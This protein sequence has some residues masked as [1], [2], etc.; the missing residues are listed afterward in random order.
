MSININKNLIIFKIL[1][2]VYFFVATIIYYNNQKTQ[3]FA[4]NFINY[5]RIK[6]INIQQHFVQKKIIEKQI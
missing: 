5:F 2:F 3:T 6:H 4:K 1:K